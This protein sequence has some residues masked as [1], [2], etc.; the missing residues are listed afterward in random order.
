MA[1]H[2]KLNGLA[3][4][5]EAIDET[6]VLAKRHIMIFDY[7]LENMGFNSAMRSERLRDFLLQNPENRLS[8]VL[9]SVDYLDRY[10]PRIVL[11]LKRFSHNM[12]VHLIVPEIAGVYDPFCLADGDHYVRRFHFDDPRGVMGI[13]DSH[14]GRTLLLRFEQIWRASTVA[15]HA[16]TTGL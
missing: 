15:V 12:A 16:D 2:R 6:I 4:Y 3:E 14:E 1:E 5:N 9:K 13:S 8:I 10:C 11:L 7:N